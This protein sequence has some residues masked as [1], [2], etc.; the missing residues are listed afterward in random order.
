MPYSV[1]HDVGLYGDEVKR[2][3]SHQVKVKLSSETESFESPDSDDG[4]ESRSQEVRTTISLK[5][6]STGPHVIGIFIK[7]ALRWYLKSLEKRR[8]SSALYVIPTEACID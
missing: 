8:K 6:S 4:E 5:I 3:P 7:T 2:I 1:L